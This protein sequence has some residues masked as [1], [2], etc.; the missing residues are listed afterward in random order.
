MNTLRL[1]RDYTPLHKK[2]KTTIT[3]PTVN[4]VRTIEREVEVPRGTPLYE[5]DKTILEP[6]LQDYLINELLT[7]IEQEDIETDDIKIHGDTIQRLHHSSYADLSQKEEIDL[8]YLHFGTFAQKG[9]G[10]DSNGE[11]RYN[12]LFNYEAKIYMKLIIKTEDA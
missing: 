9:T 8:I 2:D 7:T 5:Y 11:R 4:I 12:D 1:N 6:Y 10:H 3:L